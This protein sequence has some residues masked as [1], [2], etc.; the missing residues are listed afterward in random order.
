[1]RQWP[2]LHGA[3]RRRGRE[4]LRAE[5]SKSVVQ[6]K[7]R[8]PGASPVPGGDCGPH[9]LQEWGK[10]KGADAGGSQGPR[11]SSSDQRRGLRPHGG[12]RGWGGV[13]WTSLR[14]P[15]AQAEAGRP[16]W[17][18]PALRPGGHCPAPP[19]CRSVSPRAPH[20][21]SAPLPVGPPP[22]CSTVTPQAT[23]SSLTSPEPQRSVL[24]PSCPPPPKL[25]QCPRLPSTHP[26]LKTNRHLWA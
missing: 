13:C 22:L 3:A 8:Q 20:L 24:S 6:G 25:H 2:D 26:P 12:V 23:P 21:A 10:A 11:P 7:G 9:P 4:A 1:M 17:G 14:C 18:P 19:S 16:G 15:S 5:R